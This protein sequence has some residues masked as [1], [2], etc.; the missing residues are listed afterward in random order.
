MADADAPRNHRESKRDSQ[1]K[2]DAHAIYSS[3]H[4]RAQQEALERRAKA[5]SKKTPTKK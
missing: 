1:K 3:K 2:K 4:I 5:S